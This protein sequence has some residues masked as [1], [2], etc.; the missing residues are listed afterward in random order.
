MYYAYLIL[1]HRDFSFVKSMKPV[2]AYSYLSSHFQSELDFQTHALFLLIAIINCVA[3]SNASK[4][5]LVL[6]IGPPKVTSQFAL[7]V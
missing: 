7:G 5:Y 4:K 3:G 1:F 6:H 2:I